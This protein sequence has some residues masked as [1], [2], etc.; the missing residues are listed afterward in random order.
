MYDGFCLSYK[1]HLLFVIA[2][3]TKHNLKMSQTTDLHKLIKLHTSH[4][5][6]SEWSVHNL[7]VNLTGHIDLVYHDL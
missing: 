1:E 6:K 3:A 5:C 7:K 2:Y 4:N